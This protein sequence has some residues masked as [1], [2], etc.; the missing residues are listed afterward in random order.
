LETAGQS[1]LETVDANLQWL[2]Q[3][4]ADI[5]AWL[6]NYNSAS[7]LSLNPIM[8]ITI[9]SGYLIAKYLHNMP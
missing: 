5:S 8:S 3:Y 4:S 9:L 7:Y 2:G 1:A 6:V